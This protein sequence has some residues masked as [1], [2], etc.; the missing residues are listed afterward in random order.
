[1]NKT[2]MNY[3]EDLNVGC[4]CPHEDAF[5]PDGAKTYFRVLKSNELNSDCFLPTKIAIT[6]DKPLPSG[7]DDCI[8]KSVSIFDS[9]EEM[10]NGYF[11]LP[12]NRGKKKH[13]G[14]LQLKPNDGVLKQTFRK[15]HHSWWRSQ[16]FDIATVTIKE[17]DL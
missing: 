17:I 6:I 16:A 11:K 5:V 2:A 13:I 8:G 7:F 4:T 14:I 3:F 12:H 1:M 10:V 15:S 9:L